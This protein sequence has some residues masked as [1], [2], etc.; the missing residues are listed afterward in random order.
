MGEEK[1][2]AAKGRPED[3]PVPSARPLLIWYVI[4]TLILLWLWQDA[5]RQVAFRTIPYSE[6]KARLGRGE[7][8]E[9]TVEQDEITGK[10]T[11]KAGTGAA[12][13]DSAKAGPDA[14]FGFRS[15]RI[16]DPKLVEDLQKAGVEFSGVRPGVLSQLFW[17][18]L[19]PIGAIAL[20]WWV[21]ARRV[22]A[23]G[24]SVL[25]FGQSR[26]RLIAEKST[27]ITFEDV[28]GCDEA[29]AELVE[30]V[31]FLRHAERYRSLGARIPKGVLLLGPPG[32]AR[33][34][35]RGPWPARPGSR[36]SR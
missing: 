15:V 18:W 5:A 8:S 28:A 11:P 31:D 22:G 16:E 36:S 23:A 12:P 19:L 33:R 14:P 10:V 34:S 21:M 30:I 27:G 7:V 3:G 2:G 1:G 9:C 24:E 25:G 35:W 26:A 4:L 20:F 6:F 17:A 29:K 32:P 13:A